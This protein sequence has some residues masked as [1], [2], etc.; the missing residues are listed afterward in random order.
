MD[1][2]LDAGSCNN[3]D[4]MLSSLERMIGDMQEF[5]MFLG[6]YPRISQQPYDAY[7]FHDQVMF[8]RQMEKETIL[9]F[10]LCR[11][12]ARNGS[13]GVLPIIGPARVGKST[14]VEHVCLDERV[15]RRFSSIVFFSGND[16][17]G[18]N[19]ATLKGSGVIKHQN[20]ASTPHG[21]SLAVIELAGDMD[22][23]TWRGLYTSAASHLT[24]GSKIILTSRSEKIASLGTAQSL[25]LKFLS[26]EAYWYFFKTAAFGSTDPGEHPNLAALGMEIVVHMN[27]SFVAANTVASLL[28]TNL[29]T[30]F[31]RRVLRCLRDFASKH[32]SMF[33]EHPTNL[34]QKDQ[35]VYMWTMAKTSNVVVMRDIYHEPSPK[36]SE[37]PRIT[38]QDVLSG[39]VMSE[40]TFQAVAW[41][42]R[43]PPCYT[44]LVSFIVSRTDK[45]AVLAPN[46][47]SLMCG[48]LLH[49]SPAIS[50][51]AEY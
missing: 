45:H 33:G 37:V 39:R 12:A 21:D 6:S 34:L 18:G 20:L 8:G 9:S 38:A 26:Q 43:I 19:L 24:P 48:G 40:G 44:Y 46:I 15:R 11:E 35:P 4:K 41:R 16:L 13:L 7:L 32:L 47:S 42:S 51:Q 49:G 30:R 3:L 22:E 23:E 17:N 10:L 29:D 50:P 14:L 25:V 36:I 5:V 27:R 1:L 31:W 2:V 28:R